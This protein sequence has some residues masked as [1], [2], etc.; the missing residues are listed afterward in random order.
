MHIN[1][2]ISCYI[3]NYKKWIINWFITKP[4]QNLKRKK[5]KA[6]FEEFI[7]F[8]YFVLFNCSFTILKNFFYITV[9]VI[10]L[11]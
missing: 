10:N 3:I 1:G 9:I 7:Y 5:S 4:C 6:Y 2:L 8:P 11:F